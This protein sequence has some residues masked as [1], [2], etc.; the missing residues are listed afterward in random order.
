MFCKLIVLHNVFLQLSSNKSYHTPPC[1][2]GVRGEAF[3]GLGLLWGF[4]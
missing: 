4:L 1:G 2:G 3:W